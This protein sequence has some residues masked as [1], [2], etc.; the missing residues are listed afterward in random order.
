[1]SDFFAE[2]KR[3][4]IYRVGAA[5]V[6]IAWALTQVVD[7]LSQ[8][9]E[10]APWIAQS[11]IVLLAIGFPLALI[12]AWV[13]ESKPHEAV[14]AAMRSKPTIL[15]WALFGAVALLI[16]V[17]GYQT[18]VRPSGRQVG[19]DAAREA[20]ASPTTALSVAVLPFANL[21]GDASQEFFSDGIT[22]EITGALTKVPDLRVVAR[23]S[24]FEFKGQNRNVQT[25]GKQL[26]A[27]H[28]IEGSVR[29]AGERVRITAQLI[30][31]NDGTHVWAQNYDRQLT[32]IFAIQE[33]IAR[34]IATSLRMSLSLSPG[35]QL[36]YS[37]A[38]DAQSYE[39]FLRG[40]AAFGRARGAYA[41]QLA[42]LEPVVQ[43]NPNYAP[44]WAALARAYRFALLAG[45]RRPL[46]EYA[47]WRANYEPKMVA[48]AR[49][50][51]ELDP[52]SIDVKVTLGSIE[53]GPR[54]WIIAEDL[55][56]A[57]AASDPNNG[58]ALFFY[59]GALIAVGRIK[60]A[61]ALLQRLHQLEPFVPLYTG[62]LGEALW[63][64]G[65]NE[66]AIEIFKQ[67]VGREGGGGA[68]GLARVYASLG[69]YKETIEQLASYLNDP[70]PMNRVIAAEA[71]RIFRSLP[72]KVAP[73]VNTPNPVG[74]SFIYLYVDAPERVIEP[75]EIE[76][77]PGS[78]IG[79]LWHPIYAPVRKTE[80]F[81]KIARGL[82]LVNY[83]RERGWPEFCRPTTGDDFECN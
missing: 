51:A 39:Q 6:V 1:M 31:A 5:Y 53:L 77:V 15:D 81:K 50:A 54:R 38:I 18:A 3:R 17:T 57:A 61:V 16:A 65:Q 69:Q 66:A 56:S 63:I 27:T 42:L 83:W 60:E 48:A 21:S 47:S 74:A 22:E 19:V 14:A 8:V 24:A 26:Q 44:A 25:I 9:F 67:N 76:I 75:Y 62:N 34:S 46:E 2:L 30:D 36:V 82:G 73:A 33:D 80:R 35:Q 40:K 52:E 71:I 12:A 64:D 32:D 29:K 43:K 59:S 28:L 68:V 11:A 20:A 10:L 7:V 79:L 55:L 49:R 4:H 78:D 23:T 58:E 70:A 37:R 45:Q 13:I 72:E 41:E